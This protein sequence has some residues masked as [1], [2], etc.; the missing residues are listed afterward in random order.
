[1]TGMASFQKLAY[2]SGNKNLCPAIWVISHPYN[3]DIQAM[4]KPPIFWTWATVFFESRQPCCR[5]FYAD[6]SACS[7]TPTRLARSISSPQLFKCRHHFL[8]RDLICR[9]P[10]LEYY[11]IN[12]PRR[13]SPLIG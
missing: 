3:T 2:K 8:G 10:F 1:M 13:P 9:F 11:I 4:L 5:A 6:T 7:I 12:L